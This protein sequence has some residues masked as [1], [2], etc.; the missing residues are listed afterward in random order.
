M[1]SLEAVV[2]LCVLL[3]AKA[4][5]LWMFLIPQ[6]TSLGTRPSQ[7]GGS[8][9]ETTNPLA[10]NKQTVSIQLCRKDIT[11]V[12]YHMRNPNPSRPSFLIFPK[13]VGQGLRQN[14]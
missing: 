6:P 14:S 7:V 13:A 3:D 12:L 4:F 9:T 11:M 1:K 8:G 10:D 2:A 5:Q